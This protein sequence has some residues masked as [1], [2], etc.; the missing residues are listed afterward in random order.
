VR[1][2]N[3]D[4]REKGEDWRLDR[5]WR[6]ETGDWRLVTGDVKRKGIYVRG[7]DGGGEKY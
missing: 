4:W 6:L 2:T 5:D 3:R 1:L 7:R